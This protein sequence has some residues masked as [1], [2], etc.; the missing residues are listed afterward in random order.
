VNRYIK[1]I[2]IGLNVLW[3]SMPVAAQSTENLPDSIATSYF[4]ALQSGD[5]AKCASLAHPSSLSNIRKSADKFVDSLIVMDTFGDSIRSYFGVASKEEYAK[6]SDS[7]VFQHVVER[8]SQQP[9][10]SEILKATKYK[11]IGNL[12][13]RDDLVHVLYRSNVELFDSN[14][15]RLEFAT[16]KKGNE[17]FGIVGVVAEVKLGRPDADRADLISVK[18]DGVDWKI[19]PGADI[20][21]AI[22]EWERAINEFQENMRKFEAA[23]AQEV[24]AKQKTKSKRRARNR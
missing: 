18:K 16:F 11:V 7:M 8:I 14:G 24:K 21:Q 15:N 13:E 20:E 6:L 4:G 2:L 17:H 9:G 3:L 19:L 23:V 22:N 5:W 10:Y 12:K 1:L